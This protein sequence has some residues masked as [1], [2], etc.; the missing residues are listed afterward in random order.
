M[1]NQQELIPYAINLME[2]I[3]N[4]ET[5][6]SA[7]QEIQQ[8]L[9]NDQSIFVFIQIYSTIKKEYIQHA[10]I[11]FARL[12]IDIH[13]SK[14]SLESINKILFFLKTL[15]PSANRIC[16][17]EIEIGILILILERRSEC[18]I[19]N[20]LIFDSSL[21]S[22]SYWILV[23][24]YYLY[25][26]SVEEAI[27]NIDFITNK[28]HSLTPSKDLGSYMGGLFA[29]ANVCIYIKDCSYIEPFLDNFKEICTHVIQSISSGDHSLNYLLS[30]IST[31]LNFL[32]HYDHSSAYILN[33]IDFSFLHKSI[34]AAQLNSIFSL[35]EFSLQIMA[36]LPPS[37][38]QDIIPLSFIDQ[39]ISFILAI[40][41]AWD[42]SSPDTEFLKIIPYTNQSEMFSAEDFL[43]FLKVLPREEAKEASLLRI[44]QLFKINQYGAALAIS[45]LEATIK[46]YGP[47]EEA[48]E[49]FFMCLSHESGLVKFLALS[50][51]GDS[52]DIFLQSNSFP[53]NFP[54][55][56]PII[57]NIGLDFLSLDLKPI[58]RLPNTCLIF[59]IIVQFLQFD[60]KITLPIFDSL[61]HLYRAY[62]EN[63]IPDEQS[64]SVILLKSFLGPIYDPK[65]NFE[66]VFPDLV[67]H[68]ISLTNS[69]SSM[70]RSSVY[71]LLYKTFFLSKL[72]IIDYDEIIIQMGI[73]EISI[74]SN[75]NND[76][77]IIEMTNLLSLLFYT[78]N[79]HFQIPEH[80][81][82]LLWYLVKCNSIFS[83]DQT[84]EN[85]TSV[86]ASFSFASSVEKI[87]NIL[88]YSG[89][90]INLLPF[91]LH[92]LLIQAD[93]SNPHPLQNLHFLLDTTSISLISILLSQSQSVINSNIPNWC[94]GFFQTPEQSF[95]QEQ[96]FGQLWNK[97][98]SKIIDKNG[99]P[100][101]IFQ[102]RN[103]SIQHIF[104]II[105]TL[106]LSLPELIPFDTICALVNF[107][108][109]TINS[110]FTILNDAQELH[111]TLNSVLV[112]FLC[113]I[114]GNLV[115]NLFKV[116]LAQ[117]YISWVL[118][119]LNEP[120]SIAN[121]G[122][123]DKVIFDS[124]RSIAFKC[125]DELFAAGSIYSQYLIEAQPNL[126]TEIMISC[127]MDENINMAS[128]ALGLMA[129]A[130]KLNLIGPE[131]LQIVKE[132][133][134]LVNVENEELSSYL[135]LRDSCY[136][137]VSAMYFSPNC[138][139][140][141]ISFE[142]LDLILKLSPPL[143]NYYD[144]RA[145]F[146]CIIQLFYGAPDL[147]QQFFR[148]FG[149]YLLYQQFNSMV[150]QLGNLTF[151]IGK[152]I[153]ICLD[154]SKDPTKMIK[155]FCE[156]EARYMKFIQVLNK[157]FAF[158]ASFC[159]Q[160]E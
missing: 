83:T 143:Y 53:K 29:L 128:A 114:F 84:L 109:E 150:S 64:N 131:Y 116:G 158:S 142:V 139:N 75:N 144:N 2:T 135:Y 56:I 51:I 140:R 155:D 122:E 31:F 124:I 85:P 96:F 94:E 76:E 54:S 141:Q 151:E 66:C 26:M 118:Q 71:S 46:R 12:G 78:I 107:A 121:L 70:V 11:L 133:L 123:P 61:V 101:S 153:K 93:S 42:R 45:L 8:F 86:S 149:K 100:V 90:F 67:K 97:L 6:E 47:F 7:C 65:I 145:F 92:T 62:S 112:Q 25:C 102:Q 72:K 154:E 20:D 44:T 3:N 33:C 120:N 108:I 130:A 68:S 127:I 111:S 152:L 49:F 59:R 80:R 39:H 105:Q 88:Q 19:L 24:H 156:T 136:N 115:E 87:L 160:K 138:L 30:S 10:A 55:I 73:R 60:T 147:R 98:V 63:G 77:S 81:N 9:M 43:P 58:E 99:K 104:E 103:E 17:E 4:P 129:S 110:T 157:L 159:N 21:T 113:C 52:Y 134:E 117:K 5:A 137:A 41:D 126:L 18:K 119:I 36:E 148:F 82:I 13:K 22:H 35:K 34:E 125:L 40:A 32:T 16:E 74:E 50:A 57:V 14:L 37:S 38:L 106:F 69:D 48:I 95:S 1:F 15:F 79:D 146:A 89:N 23:W 91:L 132:K 28:I 27:S